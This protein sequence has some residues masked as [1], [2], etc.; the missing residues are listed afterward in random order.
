MT[1]ATN[2]L[3]G[4]VIDIAVRATDFGDI[5]TAVNVALG[6][7][8]MTYEEFMY[9][10]SVGELVS[11]IDDL[12]TRYVTNVMRSAKHRQTQQKWEPNDFADLIALPVPAV[13]CDVV[14]TEKQWVYRM[15]Q[16]KVNRRYNT[17]L[18]DN[19]ADLVD[20]LVTAT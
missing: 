17:M 3:T 14:V 1:I 8:G 13:Y 5:R 16:G 9:G 19:V 6:R 7:I 2:G 11:F 12:P 18:L 10:I 4:A 20:V 15:R